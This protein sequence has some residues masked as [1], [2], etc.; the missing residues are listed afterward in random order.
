MLA[1][2]CPTPEKGHQAGRFGVFGRLAKAELTV[3]RVLQEVVQSFYHLLDIRTAVG[4]VLTYVV[5]AL[6]RGAD[7]RPRIL[8]PGDYVR[9]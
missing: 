1:R 8:E 3:L 7:G 9:L 4:R 6:P 2:L 5:R